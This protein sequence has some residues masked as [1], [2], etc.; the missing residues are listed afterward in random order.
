[1]KQTL[2]LV[3]LIFI[4]ASCGGGGGIPLDRKLLVNSI[5][6]YR[7]IIASDGQYEN[8]IYLQFWNSDQP[9]SMETFRRV[10]NSKFTGNNLVKYELP[11]K[12]IWR[13]NEYKIACGSKGGPHFGSFAILN[14]KNEVMVH[15]ETPRYTTGTVV[16]PV[17]NDYGDYLVAL[18]KHQTTSRSSSLFIIDEGFK[19]VYKEFLGEIEWISSDEKDSTVFYL[20]PKSNLKELIKYQ[21]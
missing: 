21:L 4:V 17:R 5:G 12:F 20:K 7:S 8:K 14:I 19:I 11:V 18:I 1:M 2:F 15:V 16:L 3:I 13:N 6:M 9:H 10:V